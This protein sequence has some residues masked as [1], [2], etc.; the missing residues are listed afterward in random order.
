[1][2]EIQR[3]PPKTHQTLQKN[4]IRYQPP[5]S[6]ISEPS[7][8]VP[9]EPSTFDPRIL[10]EPLFS[11]TSSSC[12]GK[13]AAALFLPA[14]KKPNPQLIQQSS[15]QRQGILEAMSISSSQQNGDKLW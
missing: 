1:M 14:W 6:R 15:P 9:I 4:G 5:V 7:A 12:S 8:V 10:S 13:R 2:A 3:S 11:S